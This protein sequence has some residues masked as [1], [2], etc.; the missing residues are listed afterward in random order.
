MVSVLPPLGFVGWSKRG[1][2]SFLRFDKSFKKLFLCNY[3]AGRSGRNPQAGVKTATLK[4]H[5]LPPSNH[6]LVSDPCVTVPAGFWGSLEPLGPP[7]LSDDG[8]MG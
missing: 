4:S 6:S 3:K 5:F 7:N 2:Q 1:G 8:K